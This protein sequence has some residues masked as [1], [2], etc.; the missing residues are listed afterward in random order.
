MGGEVIA[1]IID[2]CNWI[3]NPCYTLILQPMTSSEELRKYL[4]VN[5]FIINTEAAVE[6]ENRIYGIEFAGYDIKFKVKD[7]ILTVCDVVKI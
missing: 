1:G 6:D 5:G 2:R 7:G 4:Y 3:K